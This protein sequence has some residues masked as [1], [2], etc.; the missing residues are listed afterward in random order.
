M[1]LTGGH[2][3]GVAIEALDPTQTFEAAL[4]ILRPGGNQ[5]RSSMPST[6]L[7]FAQ[8]AQQ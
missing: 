4:R 2:G 8:C 7:F 6:P 3:V 5:I 1:Q